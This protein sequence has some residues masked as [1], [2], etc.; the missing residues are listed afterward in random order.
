MAG[1]EDT[2]GDDGDGFAVEEGHISISAGEHHQH[3]AGQSRLL[4]LP[5]ELLLQILS[6]LSALDLVRAS[7]TCRTLAQHASNDLLWA[8]ILNASI[9]YEI[10]DPGHF[11]SFR[12]L[13]ATYF[14][15]WF[16]PQSKVW[17]ADTE[18]T[19]NLILARY[20]HRRGVIEAYRVVAERR[21]HAFQFWE[22]NPEV[23]VQAFNP[24]IRLWLD[25]PVLLL[26]SKPTSD[27]VPVRL[28]RFLNNETRMPMQLESQAVYNSFTLC[29]NEPAG[30][31]DGWGTE[32][33]W[34]PRRIPSKYRVYRDSDTEMAECYQRPRRLAEVSETAFRV[35]R[36]A[37]MGMSVF[38]VGST[39]T[40]T[41]FGTLDPSLYTPTKEKPY[42]GI[43][44]GDY[45]AHG[46]E[47]L[48]FLQRDQSEM[49][50][51]QQT[52]QIEEV[53]ANA[54]SDSTTQNRSQNSLEAI[55]L[56]GDP[57]VPRG[58]ISF[59]AHDIGPGGFIRVTD[60]A[61][62]P[63]ARVVRSQGHVAGLGFRDGE[64]NAPPYFI[65][66]PRIQS[67]ISDEAN[68]IL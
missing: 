18:H 14:P 56:T 53:N 31:E 3:N 16:I 51:S 34:P 17:F 15:C 62:F 68:S 65:L 4:Q 47:F 26:R 60:E 67:S 45:S 57:N 35:R 46:C 63:N 36:W 55:K 37:R 19:G 33:E 29:S 64:L 13:Y 48:L 2:T 30:A 43:W 6:D 40:L 49:S 20:D 44:V 54:N 59:L 5:S 61:L 1:D 42:Q 11:A 41:T 7:R 9:P 39:E 38:G 10:D 22:R 28:L 52:T 23:M 50:A 24:K 12:S 8:D 58:E 32:N 21:D 27:G 66:L 25:D